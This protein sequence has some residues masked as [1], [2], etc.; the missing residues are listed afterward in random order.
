MAMMEVRKP[1]KVIKREHKYESAI[2]SK[3]PLACQ[4][5]CIE[6]HTFFKE[7]PV[8]NNIPRNI[9]VGLSNGMFVRSHHFTN[10]YKRTTP[11]SYT[12][13]SFDRMG[14]SGEKNLHSINGCRITLQGKNRNFHYPS[15]NKEYCLDGLA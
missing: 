6:M 3:S 15:T 12:E 7:G 4:D 14:R 5:F 1:M 8:A 10:N 2:V 13:I 11:S 9:S